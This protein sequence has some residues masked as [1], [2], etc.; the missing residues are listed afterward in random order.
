MKLTEIG[1]LSSVATKLA[2]EI[3]ETK[4]V[5][6]CGGTGCRA[7]ES[8][9]LLVLLQKAV[10]DR[11]L[12]IIIKETGSHGLSENGPLMVI[13]PDN[14]FYQ[15]LKPKDIDE[16]VER[17]LMKDEVIERLLYQEPE[18]GKKLEKEFDIPFYKKQQRLVFAQ[19]Y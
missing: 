1:Q 11:N 16:I 6:L 2:G 18:S 8:E 4:T 12:D 7:S 14:I 9:K 10:A 19:E 13:R 3:P 5:S 15:R 17:S